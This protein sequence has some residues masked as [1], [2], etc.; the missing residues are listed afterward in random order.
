MTQRQEC[1]PVG[2]VP[3]AAIAI[4]PATHTPCHTCSPAMHAPHHT[5]PLPCMP[6]PCTPPAMH[7]PPPCMPIPLP[8]MPPHCGQ[9]SWHT[10]VKTLPCRNFG[11][12]SKNCSFSVDT[13][14]NLTLLSMTLAQRN[15]LV[16]TLYS[17]KPKSS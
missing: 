10:L 5:C 6:L 4:F 13:R 1:I 2:C 11:A 14:C 9:N 7:M 15:Q 12:G 3:P 17:I 16:V 8:C